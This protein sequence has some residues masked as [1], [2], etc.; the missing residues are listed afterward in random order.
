MFVTDGYRSCYGT[1]TLENGHIFQ[2]YSNQKGKAIRGESALPYCIESFLHRND[3]PSKIDF[4]SMG[5]FLPKRDGKN[6]MMRAN[7]SQHVGDL[8]EASS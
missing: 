4:T 3:L 8:L 2:V 6:L 1:V 7:T 5:F